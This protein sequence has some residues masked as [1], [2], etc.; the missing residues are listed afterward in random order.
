MRGQAQAW[1]RPDS[2][3]TSQELS[4]LLLASPG[5]VEMAGITALKAQGQVGTGL[6]TGHCLIFF[7]C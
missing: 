3:A 1:R 2:K 5:T 6:A 7:I 4:L